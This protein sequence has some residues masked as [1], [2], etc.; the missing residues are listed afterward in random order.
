MLRKIDLIVELGHTQVFDSEVYD[1][2]ACDMIKCDAEGMSWRIS[3]LYK[4]EER[5]SDDVIL[6]CLETLK[7]ETEPTGN[8]RFDAAVITQLDALIRKQQHKM[9][10]VAA[11]PDRSVSAQSYVGTRDLYYG[12]P[13]LTGAEVLADESS[14]DVTGTYRVKL[15]LLTKKDFRFDITLWQES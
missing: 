15:K 12:C 5:K 1:K 14:L 11:K 3:M 9:D 10:K 2:G 13:D 7:R 4:A 6:D 8:E